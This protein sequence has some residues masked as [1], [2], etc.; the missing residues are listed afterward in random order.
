MTRRMKTMAKK[1]NDAEA[2][3]NQVAQNVYQ[4]ILEQHT[5]HLDMPLRSLNNVKYDAKEGYF[6]LLGKMKTRTLTAS[7]AKTFAQTLRMMTLSKKLIA[8]NDIATK[9]DAYYQSK[10]DWG[11]AGFGEQAESDAIMDD[12]EAMLM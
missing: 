6:E 9:R 3:I 8:T 7:T 2:A 10:G 12:M 1:S 5:P 11:K 4:T